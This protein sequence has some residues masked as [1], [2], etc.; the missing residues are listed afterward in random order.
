VNYLYRRATSNRLS[1]FA[2]SIAIN[3][4]YAYYK[5]VLY[6]LTKLGWTPSEKGDARAQR[7][8]LQ[9]VVTAYDLTPEQAKQWIDTSS[10]SV[11]RTSR[12]K[13]H[14]NRPLNHA[15]IG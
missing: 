10:R 6:P 8:L 3:I 4:E 2:A 5:M 13:P 14:R 7:R 15:G 9:M 11:P 1:Y 12:V